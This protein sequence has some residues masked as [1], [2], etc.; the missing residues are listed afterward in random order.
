MNSTCEQYHEKEKKKR[1]KRKGET[2]TLRLT[3]LMLQILNISINII[4]SL[5]PV[6]TNIQTQ[7][8]SGVLGEKYNQVKKQ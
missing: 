6:S 3:C 5:I 7:Y 1:G 8:T 4:S 2:K